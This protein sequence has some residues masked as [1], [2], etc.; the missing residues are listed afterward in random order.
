MTALTA[1]RGRG[2]A[3][4][5]V[6]MD[7]KNLDIYSNRPIPWSRPLA[8]LAS[9]HHNLMSSTTSKHNIW[10]TERVRALAAKEA[11]RCNGTP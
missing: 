2:G 6:D 8:E 7:Q 3:N 9:Q 5:F 1:G 10:W 11:I 4:G